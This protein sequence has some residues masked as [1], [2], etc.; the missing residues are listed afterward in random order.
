MRIGNHATNTNTGGLNGDF[1]EMIIYNTVL[2]ST[3][4]RRVESYLAIK[5]GITLDP[6]LNYLRS[7]GNTIYPS[8]GTHSGYVTDIAGIGRDD[9]SGLNQTSSRSQNTDYM[10][11]VS[12]ASS[13]GNNDFLIWGHNNGSLTVPNSVDVH[14]TTVQ[15]RLSRVWR[16]AETGNVGTFTMTFDLSAVPGPKVQADLRLLVD[17]DGDGFADND[18]TPITGTLAGNIFTVTINPGVKPKQ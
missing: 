17:R 14:R 1:A 18:R 10:L 4:R 3:D 7:D 16:V 5:Y 15:R 2:S 6:S 12:G 11:T 13:L 9:N 8:T